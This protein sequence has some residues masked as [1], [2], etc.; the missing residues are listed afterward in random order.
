MR[1]QAKFYQVNIIDARNEQLE[2]LDT[3]VD[4]DISKV[5]VKATEYLKE[6]NLPKDKVWKT[7]P[8][9]VKTYIEING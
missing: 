3:I 1:V 4:G 9:V 8:I 7:T 2:L 6:H 5:G